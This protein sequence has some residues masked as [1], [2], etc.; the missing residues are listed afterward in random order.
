[1][2]KRVL[3]LAIVFTCFIRVSLA[4]IGIGTVNPH[5]SSKLDIHS[6]TKGFLP[7]RLTIVQR[8]NI[9]QPATGLMIYNL[10]KHCIEWNNGTPTNPDW[11]KP[12][13]EAEIA[14]LVNCSS[15]VISNILNEN[16]LISNTTMTISYTGG[17]GL[18]YEEQVFSVN[19]IIATLPAGSL[20]KGDGDLVF[21]LS[22]NS[23]NV[24]L[25]DLDFTSLFGVN[26]TASIEVED[27]FAN[28]SMVVKQESFFSGGI[29]LFSSLK[30]EVYGLPWSYN[31]QLD[32]P[33]IVNGVPT[34]RSNIN[35]KLTRCITQ[36]NRQCFRSGT[37]TL[38]LPNGKEFKVYSTPPPNAASTGTG[39]NTLIISRCED[40]GADLPSDPQDYSCN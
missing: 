20:N 31:N 9:N 2:T 1:M 33:I 13:A 7:P 12:C 18:S 32:Y 6:T 37:F 23:G 25:Y 16:S 10:D 30:Q 19:G 17:N 5:T 11:Y 26:C 40:E 15:P 35:S 21:N 8:D 4:Q 36:P 34:T 39:S 3:L 28:T 27:V 29:G 22:G 14:S 24:G 38:G